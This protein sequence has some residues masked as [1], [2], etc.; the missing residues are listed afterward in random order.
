MEPPVIF[1]HDP[2]PEPCA[3]TSVNGAYGSTMAEY[4]YNDMDAHGAAQ[5]AKGRAYRD[6]ELNAQQANAPE[7]GIVE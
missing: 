4:S 7:A 3:E 6:M 5:Y 2:P 1:P